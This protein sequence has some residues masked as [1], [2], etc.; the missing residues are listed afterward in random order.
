MAVS[1]F[2]LYMYSLLRMFV[3]TLIIIGCQRRNYRNGDISR[4]LRPI[5]IGILRHFRLK[6][7]KT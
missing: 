2:L 3:H 7:I 1:N 4:T 6:V 5:F